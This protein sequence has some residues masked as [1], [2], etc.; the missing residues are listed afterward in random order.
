FSDRVDAAAACGFEALECQFPYDTPAEVVKR[1]LDATGLELVLL[2]ARAGDMAAGDRGLGAVQDRED[3]FRAA[4]DEAGRYAETVGCPRVHVMAGCP[5]DGG[6]SRRFV[7]R[8]GWAADR[9]APAG[10]DI[11][12]EPM[13]RRDVPGYLLGTSRQAERVIE[14]TGRSNV[15]LQFD[16]Y[17]LQIQEGDL[18]ENFRRCLPVIGHVQ[19]SSLP[20][21]NEPDQGEIDHHW[22]FAQFDAAGYD[23][24]IG[25]EYRPRVA[26]V[27]G[28]AWAERYGISAPAN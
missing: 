3:E 24:W 14:Q 15:R 27:D 10:I 9:L 12:V 23:G 18:L 17:H 21:R 2:N 20:G 13:N 25:C 19:I 16:T 22:L 5:V 1:R 11:L 6:A 8:V 28:L 26:T 4:I 7:D